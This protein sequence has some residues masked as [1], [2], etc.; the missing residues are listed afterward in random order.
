MVIHALSSCVNHGD[1]EVICD[2][3]ITHKVTYSLGHIKVTCDLR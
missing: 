1:I 3:F 2:L